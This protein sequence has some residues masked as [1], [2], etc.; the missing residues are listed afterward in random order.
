MKKNAY[1]EAVAKH[2][3]STTQALV[4]QIM[5]G[6]AHHVDMQREA[7]AADRARLSDPKRYGTDRER[8]CV[9]GAG[10]LFLGVM[11]LESALDAVDDW[12]AEHTLSTRVREEVKQLDQ[13]ALK[14]MVARVGQVSR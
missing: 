13:A 12:D 1:V 8:L 6:L 11:M 14:A 5:R 2:L 9:A 7:L 3:P 10:G 4:P